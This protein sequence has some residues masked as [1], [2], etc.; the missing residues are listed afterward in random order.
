M[1][2]TLAAWLLGIAL[3]AAFLSVP[4][5][6]SADLDTRIADAYRAMY[7]LDQ[8]AGI[9]AARSI[10]AAAPNESRTHR[11]LAVA[12]WIEVIFQ[13]GSVTID[14]YLGNIGKSDVTM[15]KPP[16]ALDAEFKQEVERAIELANARLAANP[17][18]IQAKYDLGSAYGLQASYLASVEGR[19][20]SALLSARHA[21]D[22]QE[23]VLE[24]DPKR[25]GAGVVVGTYRYLVGGLALPSRMVA[26]MMGF[27]GDKERGIRLIQAATRD[28][29]AEVEAKLALILIFSR[30]GRHV[31]ALRLIGELAAKFP[32][33]RIL[34]LEQGSAALRAARYSE[35]EGYL[36]KGL[37]LFEHDNR[38]KL[39]GEHALWLYKRGI[40]RL[41]QN[42]RAE[43]S[44]DLTAALQA[45][46]ENW[47]R[48]RIRLAL[49]KIADLDGKRTDALSEYRS[50]RE[51][52]TAASDPAC[53]TEA[54]RWLKQP[55][56][57]PRL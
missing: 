23:E 40:A 36:T 54:S 30:E 20:T 9:S 13:R 42:H 10:V 46:P 7:N 28:P 19:M 43:A 3:L 33:N 17:N 51:I 6:Q 56:V 11:L 22:V 25:V 41:Y 39:P 48:G 29:N 1:S 49:G 24:R 52:A 8:D 21:F 55:F 53:S 18:D 12:L 50:A 34:V 4:H 5:A 2:R 15:P 45:G 26:Y 27:G 35:A 31:D 44:A 38:R 57:L 47:I 16:P 32:R 14:H 37:G